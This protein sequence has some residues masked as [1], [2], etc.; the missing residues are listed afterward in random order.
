MLFKNH[1]IRGT[2][3]LLPS[4]FHLGPPSVRRGTL[5][6]FLVRAEAVGVAGL[7]AVVETPKVHP[8]AEGKMTSLVGTSWDGFI[9]V[10]LPHYLQIV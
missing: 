8:S 2:T 4:T 5:V 1:K 9:R 6:L 7:V 3:S 10:G